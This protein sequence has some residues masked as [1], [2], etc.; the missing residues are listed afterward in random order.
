MQVA[1]VA[2]LAFV[3]IWF[4]ALRHRS[5]KAATPATP[6]PAQTTAVPTTSKPQPT[7]SGFGR[8]VEKARGAA[9]TANGAVAA[10]QRTGESAA[11]SASATA[12]PTPASKP[13]AK[14]APA[15]SVAAVAVSGARQAGAAVAPLRHKA[16]IEEGPAHALP[17]PIQSA[18]DARKVIVLL[19]WQP[20]SSDDRAVHDEVA[21]LSTHG[22]KVVVKSAPLADLGTYGRIVAGA[23]VQ[24]SP[25]VIVIDGN[26]RART[27]TGFVDGEVIDQAVLAALAR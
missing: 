17:R 8:A 27:L 7:G 5:E 23:K 16:G 10:E 12:T 26:H 1:L 4:V 18:L 15:P 19:F 3:A 22:G 21:G 13:A 20:N 11:P 9:R 25:T 2:T 6:A 14:A 24:Q